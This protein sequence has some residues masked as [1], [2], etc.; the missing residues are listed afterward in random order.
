MIK[1]IERAK[2]GMGSV[3]DHARDAVVGAADHAERGVESATKS[4]VQSAR[5]AGEQVRDAAETAS[6]GAQRQLD[7]TAQA[8]DRG[9]RRT[10]E[11]GVRAAAAATDYVA[12]NPGRALLL[13]ASAGFVLGML[14]RRRR[15]VA[16]LGVALA[17][18]GTATRAE[19]RLLEAD[20]VAIRSEAEAWP[21]EAVAPVAPVAARSSAVGGGL[22]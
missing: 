18:A 11:E 19:D 17:F 1:N 16:A 3:I 8:I 2:D 4:V 20:Q 10:R 21:A 14:M 15:L 6:R 7:S 12:R 22:R 9:Y 13:V 5:V